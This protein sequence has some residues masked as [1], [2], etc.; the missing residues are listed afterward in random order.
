MAM[1]DS[2]ALVR[3]QG[4]PERCNISHRYAS[5]SLLSDS[6]DGSS[7]LIVSYRFLSHFVQD[8]H[9]FSHTSGIASLIFLVTS[10]FCP[11][12]T[13]VSLWLCHSQGARPTAFDTRALSASPAFSA[14]APLPS[15]VQTPE[16]TAESAADREC[17]IAGRG[18]QLC[19]GHCGIAIAE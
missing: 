1:A 11:T 4:P 13:A 10:H 16:P 17:L 18:L 15:P 7:R 9:S 2:S 6:L 19:R 3:S 14:S 12:L 8:R 5:G